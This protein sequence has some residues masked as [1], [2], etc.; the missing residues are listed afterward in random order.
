M[1][2]LRVIPPAVNIRTLNPAIKWD[3]FQMRVPLSSSDLPCRGDKPLVALASSGI[4]GSNGHVVIEGPPRMAVPIASIPEG[5]VV[6]MACGLS[7]RSATSTAESLKELIS[8]PSTDLR[9]LSTVLGRRSRQ[10]TWR[11]FALVDRPLGGPVS[12][13]APQYCSR[14]KNTLVLL[15]SGQGPQHIDSESACLDGITSTH[16]SIKWVASCTSNSRPSAR[17]SWTWTAYSRE[18]RGDQSSRTTVFS[19]GTHAVVR[20][21]CGL[22]R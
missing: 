9:A 13:S 15:F 21:I 8:A 1:I 11:S 12:F 4:G 3:E 5:P 6:L 2:E 19:A 18:L 22:Y 20:M 14:N 7:S 16:E 10:M 17:A